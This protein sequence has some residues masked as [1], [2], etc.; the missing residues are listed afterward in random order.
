[1][2][3]QDALNESRLVANGIQLAQGLIVIEQTNIV[4]GKIAVAEYIFEFAAFEG[5]SCLQWQR[6]TD[7]PS[8]PAS[9]WTRTAVLGSFF[10]RRVRPRL[11]AEVA[12]AWAAGKQK[13]AEPAL[14]ASV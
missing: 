7:H 3:G 10:I 6:E 9:G 12:A 13:R 1:M 14:P 2:F 8:L 4:R 11:E 5:G